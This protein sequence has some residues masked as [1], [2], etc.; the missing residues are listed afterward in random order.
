MYRLT[1]LSVAGS[2][3]GRV[4]LVGAIAISAFVV[5]LVVLGFLLQPQAALVRQVGSIGVSS[6]QI[7]ESS[8]R[9]H[10][11]QMCIP[12]LMTRCACF[13]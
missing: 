13:Q 5:P 11:S 12:H 9:C 10:Q 6:S 1:F 7:L 4:R 8:G 3:W 2:P